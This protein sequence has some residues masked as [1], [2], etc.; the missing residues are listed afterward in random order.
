VLNF[1][2]NALFS[3]SRNNFLGGDDD[4]EEDRDDARIKLGGGG[5]CTRDPESHMH[6]PCHELNL[7]IF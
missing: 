7:S 6:E 4:D 1:I 3:L 5:R 2:D